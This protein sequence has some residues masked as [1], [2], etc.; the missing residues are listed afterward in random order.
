MLLVGYVVVKSPSHVRLSATPWTAACQASLSLP[1]PEVYPSSCPL[2]WSCHPAISS[3]YAL[4]FCPQS[5]QHQGLF[6]WVVWLHQE[7]KIPELELCQLCELWSLS[8]AS[9]LSRVFRVDFPEDWLVWSSCC[10]RDF[11]EKVL[12]D[13]MTACNL[14]WFMD[15]TFQVP[16]QYC[17]L[18]H[19]ILLSS[20]D[21]STTDHHFRF[22]PATSF[23]PGL[24]VVLLCSSPVA[25]WAPSDNSGGRIFRYHMFLSFYTIHEVLMASILGWFAIPPSSGS[26]FVRTLHYVPSILGSPAQHGS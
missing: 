7:T 13:L 21:T 22:G 17:F 24:L 11:Q 14:L 1:S 19:Q 4:F 9:V 20:P 3:S 18:Q 15:L 5:F 26:C 16:M 6:Q 23:F 10:P 8:S 2:H 25:Y 12:I